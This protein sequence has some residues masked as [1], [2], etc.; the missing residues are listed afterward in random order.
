MSLKI[1]NSF[2]F[3]AHATQ[4]NDSQCPPASH[5]SSFIAFVSRKSEWRLQKQSAERKCR[6]PLP[7]QIASQRQSILNI[8]HINYGRFRVRAKCRK[9]SSHAPREVKIHTQPGTA[10][11]SA[12]KQQ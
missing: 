1:R 11:Y 4:S 6:G 7:I 2:T 9:K 12:A 8:R 5:R 3:L 10:T